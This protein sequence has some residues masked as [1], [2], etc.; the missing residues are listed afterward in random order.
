MSD[1]LANFMSPNK[2]LNGASQILNTQQND[3]R[4]MNY[5]LFLSDNKNI[6]TIPNYKGS[7]INNFSYIT[8]TNSTTDINL[9]SEINSKSISPVL[10][11]RKKHKFNLFQS[12]KSMKNKK[13][14]QFLKNNQSLLSP[15]QKD[16]S[17]NIFSDLTNSNKN[18]N[19]KK[20]ND[21]SVDI[22]QRV[23]DLLSSKNKFVLNNISQIPK[24][25]NK[26]TKDL[27]IMNQLFHINSEDNF[28]KQKNFQKKSEF[29]R[30]KSISPVAYIKY[31]FQKYPNDKSLYRSIK[32]QLKCFSYNEKYREALLKR[33][34]DAM[35]LQKQI[36]SM[37]IDDKNNFEINE[38]KIDQM[39]TEND[40]NS[41]KN[42][43]FDLGNIRSKKYKNKLIKKNLY[44]KDLIK[45]A[46][47]NKLNCKKD[48]FI[49][50]EDNLDYCVAITKRLVKNPQ[51]NLD[52][53]LTMMGKINEL[54]INPDSVV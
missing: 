28:L 14:N 31:N 7:K 18:I 45:E 42:F 46:Y 15:S 22:K 25:P 9:Y 44:Y 3:K 13:I 5:G 24:I 16:N 35:T 30:D 34:N 47:L 6:I 1:I 26:K 38:K 39:F 21:H 43:H 53:Q 33:V 2:I 17:K 49:S 48:Q 23:D 36:E 20:L 52:Y 37:K 40:L 19:P 11:T 8:N 41:H 32:S 10:S 50:F 51:K 12:Y 54:F 27:K 4:L 29:P